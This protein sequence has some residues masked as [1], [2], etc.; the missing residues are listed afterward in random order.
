MV[1][2][3]VTGALFFVVI[4]I[5]SKDGKNLTKII[6]KITKK[7][8]ENSPNINIL[9]KFKV[10]GESKVI[11]VVKVSKNS[12]L[13]RL[14]NR[15]HSVAEIAIDCQPVIPYESFGRTLGVPDDLTTPSTVVLRE[16]DNI[17]W[18]TVHVDY[19]GNKTSEALTIWKATAEGYLAAI[20]SGAIR[21]VFYKNL[22][23]R[24]V[25]MFWHVP[26]IEQLDMEAA[27]CPLTMNFGSNIRPESKGLSFIGSYEE[28][29]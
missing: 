9:H 27:R 4:T 13:D 11:A 15:L 26:D 3:G 2:A 7:L 22:A 8:D 17:Y 19:L 20:K 21:A 29:N 10:T 28:K 6:G 23:E 25:Q 1:A 12:D 14:I 5:L 18:L 16:D 24:E